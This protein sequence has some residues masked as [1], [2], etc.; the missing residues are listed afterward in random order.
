[1][2]TTTL[3]HLL[4]RKEFNRRWALEIF[5]QVHARVQTGD[6]VAVAIEHQGRPAQKL[7]EAA[8]LGL[9]PARVIDFR[10]YVRIETV[11]PR[12]RDVP[13]R[14]RLNF[15]DF[16]FDQR[17]RTFESVFPGNDQADGSAIL[18]RER[19]VV[20]SYRE[21]RQRIHRFIQPQPFGIRQLDTGVRAF[22]HLFYVVITFESDKCRLG[23]RL[24]QFDEVAERISDPGHDNG[25]R[26]D[27]A[28]T[29]NAL[30]Q[31]SD[32]QDFVHRKLPRLFHLAFDG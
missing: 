32:L 25:P 18:I 8:L 29:I 26:F 10:I 13:S 22:R 2:K 15:Y 19:F 23:S 1:M 20:H 28:M 7:A 14:A 16:N 24:G 3:V 27:A 30:L 12:I 5:L 6:L 4:V 21:Q 11:F 17:F 31:R 9:A